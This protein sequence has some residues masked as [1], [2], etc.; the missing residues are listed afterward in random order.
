MEI[1]TRSPGNQKEWDAYYDLRYRVLREPWKR[2]R[3]SERNSGDTSALHFATYLGS[4][5]KAIARADLIDYKQIQIR[6]VATENGQQGKGYGKRVMLSIENHFKDSQIKELILQSRENSV[7]FY[8]SLGYAVK[9]KTYLLFNEIQ[10][11][12]MI[13]LINHES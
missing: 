5:L 1:V 7:K 13:K 12:L 3:G 9:E 2:P 11:F 8:E 4:E 6:F 10:H